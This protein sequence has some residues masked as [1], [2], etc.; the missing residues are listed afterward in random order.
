DGDGKIQDN[1]IIDKDGD[2]KIDID[3]YHAFIEANAE[4]FNSELM[5]SLCLEA[6]KAAALMD[7]L[8]RTDVTSTLNSA[9]DTFV[10]Q[11]ILPELERNPMALARYEFEL[12]NLDT[13][14]QETRKWEA[15]SRT[16]DHFTDLKQRLEDLSC[17][18]EAEVT[19]PII[20]CDIHSL[21]TVVHQRVLFLS[22]TDMAFSSASRL[23]DYLD[24]ASDVDGERIS[25]VEQ[26]FVDLLLGHLVNEQ[27]GIE[28]MIAKADNEEDLRGLLE[29]L[30]ETETNYLQPAK[31]LMKRH[32]AFVP[33]EGL[34]AELRFSQARVYRLLG[35][36][37]EANIAGEK[38]LGNVVRATMRG[39]TDTQNT[40][41]LALLNYMLS[42]SQYSEAISVMLDF[43]DEEIEQESG[44][45]SNKVE[46][47]E[48]F[49]HKR[50]EY[51]YYATQLSEE[52][53]EQTPLSP[54]EERQWL[55]VNKLWIE[56]NVSY[57][58]AL[59][60]FE[61]E[62]WADQLWQ[63][64]RDKTYQAIEQVESLVQSNELQ[65]DPEI[66]A[67]LHYSKGR[68]LATQ[69]SSYLV[70]RRAS[71][72]EFNSALRLLSE[73]ER[74]EQFERKYG[75]RTLRNFKR[76]IFLAKAQLFN[77]P[78]LPGHYSGVATSLSSAI[79][80]APG[81]EEFRSPDD[82]RFLAEAYIEQAEL[83]SR[84]PSLW[85]SATRSTE[86][87][88]E[89]LSLLSDL[90]SYD[91]RDLKWRGRIVDTWLDFEGLHSV[92]AGYKSTRD[93]LASIIRDI[94]L[95]PPSLSTTTQQRT[96]LRAQE[97]FR[98][99]YQLHTSTPPF[100]DVYGSAGIVF[101]KCDLSNIYRPATYQVP[102][103][104]LQATIGPQILGRH[105]YNF[106]DDL[107]L[108]AFGQLGAAA[109]LDY[110][111][112]SDPEV[113]GG[114]VG[115][116]VN[117]GGG[118]E[119]GVPAARK[120]ITPWLRAEYLGEVSTPVYPNEYFYGGEDHRLVIN[121]EL[122]RE[123]W[124]EFMG[125]SVF[126][127]YN[128]DWIRYD[129]GLVGNVFTGEVDGF[130]GRNDTFKIGG[131][132]D[133][134]YFDLSASYLWG[135]FRWPGYEVNP[136]CLDVGY[137]DED[138]DCDDP[139][140][141][142]TLVN[143]RWGWNIEMGITMFDPT[144]Q[145]YLR[146]GFSGEIREAVQY[147]YIFDPTI[148]WHFNFGLITRKAGTFDFRFVHEEFEPYYESQHRGGILTWKP[149]D[150][151]GNVGFFARYDVYG[152]RSDVSPG[153]SQKCSQVGI[154]VTAGYRQ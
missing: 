129:E 97:A 6:E 84:D 83:F 51:F 27:W 50:C 12:Q 141:T 144:A 148:S 86:Q 52:L 40:A 11:N 22:N 102:L 47:G 21:D 58:L 117:W 8:T 70:K 35:E 32:S 147:D 41:K 106:S 123:I 25:I 112:I 103:G 5:P 116:N 113:R 90:S 53:V 64:Q 59:Y 54:R 2:K 60:E 49:D 95:S 108:R 26:R 127:E 134:G 76:E 62:K 133:A 99:I 57:T 96:L 153:F 107:E 154:G 139:I 149:V 20:N 30:N 125:A 69:A 145:L 16:R 114:A 79:A 24:Q 121:T 44:L 80:L 67:F 91:N 151:H 93:E 137:S 17:Q 34:W 124:D 45:F 36:F 119:I 68:L 65:Y 138:L 71:E 75:E 105:G 146:G 74:V 31:D 92:G 13:S 128:S 98:L 140:V 66:L 9:P 150:L 37:E 118:F 61:D 4:Q 56:S 136:A 87:G 135:N 115:P 33:L 38:A 29:R 39:N 73:Q 48:S 77:H 18:R 28:R 15:F 42:A 72:A 46:F 152:E 101:P 43:I 94:R 81:E 143:R 23:L 126:F 10:D 78:S 7:T 55:T 14:V 142:T 111:A 122:R 100:V 19:T 130:E 85:E 131:I 89:L 1:E 132:F 109:Y 110:K 3:E 88:L 120:V 104:E 82:L 63:E